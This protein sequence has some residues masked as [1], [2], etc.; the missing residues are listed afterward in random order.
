LNVTA[1]STVCPGAV[2]AIATSL[3]V[4][5]NFGENASTNTRREPRFFPSRDDQ[6]RINAAQFAP[7]PLHF[8]SVLNSPHVLEPLTSH[9]RTTVRNRHIRNKR[10]VIARR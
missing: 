6:F 4:G 10:R 9:H 3:R 7:R 2:D 1:I 8:A 5:I